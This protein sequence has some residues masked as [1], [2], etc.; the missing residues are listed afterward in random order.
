MLASP[1][2]YKSLRLVAGAGGST[3]GRCASTPPP[4][5]RLSA[6]LCC[7][8]LTSDN[9]CAPVTSSVACPLPPN[10]DGT[11]YYPLPSSVRTC[12]G[13]VL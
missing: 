2:P 6:R 12:M 7:A 1:T 3:A 13:P 4:N 8:S 10:P 11:F 9:T 5:P